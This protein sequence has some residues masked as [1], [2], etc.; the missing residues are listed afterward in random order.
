[1]KYTLNN[2]KFDNS[3]A[4]LPEIFYTRHHTSPLKNQYLI[5][6][7]HQLSKQIDLNPELTRPDQ[8]IEQI[9]NDNAIDGYQCLAQCYAGHQFGQFVPRLGD[10]RAL[11]LG[12]IITD[13]N[14]R[15]DLQLKGA[16]ITEY[17]RGGDGRAVLRSTI[18]EYL[19]SEAMHGLGIP[20]TRSLCMI[21]SEEEVYREKL[22]SGAILVRLAQSH[23]RFGSFEFYYYSGKHEELKILVNYV[24]KIHF[25]NLLKD[26]NPVLALLENVINFTAALIAQWQSVGFCHGVL[27]T[28]NMSIHGLTLDYG[29][30]GFL[31]EYN[32]N[33]VCNHSDYQARYAYKK[34]PEIGLFNLSCFAQTLLP[35]IDEIPEKSAEIAKQ[36]LLQYQVLYAQ[37]YA[38]KMRKKLGFIIDKRQDQA[39]CDEILNILNDQKIDYTLFFRHLSAENAYQSVSILFNEKDKFNA[40]FKRYQQR[41]VEEDISNEIRSKNQKSVN[42]K[43]ILRNYMAETAIQKAESGDYTEIDNLFKLLQRPFDEQHEYE[44]Y[45]N[46]PPQWAEKINVSCSS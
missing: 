38:E 14:D 22:E 11:L 32:V 42:P 45:A 10:G 13:N 27:N 40:W 23:I 2:L 12:E 4:E 7:N 29:P 30:F 34:Q 44:K 19:C 21:G 33:Y 25:P 31:D 37:Y 9:T 3:F 5:H 41:L 43:Y 18:R 6:Y 39:L 8:F 17:S 1:M 15:W 35:L 24:L 20:T 36:A 28:D 16:G 26:N 46:T